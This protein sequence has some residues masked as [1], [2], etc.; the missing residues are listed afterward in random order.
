MS[1]IDKKLWRDR[2]NIWEMASLC[3]TE[4]V[5][6]DSDPHQ[7]RIPDPGY[8]NGMNPDHGPPAA[9]M[10]SAYFSRPVVHHYARTPRVG[11]VKR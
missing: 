1:R 2:L 10:C 5:D 3:D 4:D 8:G 6:I 11:C 9:G 7:D